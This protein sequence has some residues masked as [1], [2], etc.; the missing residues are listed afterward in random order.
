MACPY[1]HLKYSIELEENHFLE[2]KEIYKFV[3][4]FF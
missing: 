4:E 3:K 2:L 1:K